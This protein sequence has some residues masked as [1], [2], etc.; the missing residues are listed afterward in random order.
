MTKT[1]MLLSVGALS[2]ATPAAAQNWSFV[3]S[4]D[5]NGE[6]MN[7]DLGSGRSYIFECTADA[8]K[9]TYTGVTDLM[10]FKT[11]QK[12]GDAPGSVMPEGAAQMA[13]YTGKG[14]PDFP[15][16]EY[17]P[18]AENGWD[19]TLRLKKTDRALKGLEKTE[20]MSLFTSGYT[21][22]VSVDAETRA[23]FKGFLTRCK[24]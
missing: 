6:T 9:I 11:G 17:R 8:V 1:I 20:M 7:L 23:S 24:G 19:L 18:N 14:N 16:A 21:A 2:L 22:A 10:D 4:D 3:G 12:V 15:P 13:L 5:A